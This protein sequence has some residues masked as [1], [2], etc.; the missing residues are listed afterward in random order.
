MS[1]KHTTR[2]VSTEVAVASVGLGGGVASFVAEE[3]DLSTLNGG[4]EGCAD[5][6]E[7]REFHYKMV[8]IFFRVV[9]DVDETYYRLL[10]ETR[11]CCKLLTF[12]AHFSSSLYTLNRSSGRLESLSC[13]IFLCPR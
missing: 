13:N 3:L 10:L 5:E 12:S 2:G 9:E 6:G 4:G 7:G 8:S 1:R 11:E